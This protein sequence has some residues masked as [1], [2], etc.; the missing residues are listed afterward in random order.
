MSVDF[1]EEDKLVF[2]GYFF[3]ERAGDEVRGRGLFNSS[4]WDIR[5]SRQQKCLDP[6]IT[7]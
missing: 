2:E 7:E 5:G 6:V 3:V 4:N 1:S